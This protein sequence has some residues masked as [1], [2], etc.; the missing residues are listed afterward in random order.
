M[1]C[2]EA[3]PARVRSLAVVLGSLPSV[4]HLRSLHRQ[5]RFARLSRFAS[6]HSAHRRDRT[7]AV[8]GRPEVS[9][10]DGRSPSTAPSSPG[11]ASSSDLRRI[12]DPAQSHPDSSLIERETLVVHVGARW[13]RL[14]APKRASGRASQ[15]ARD[16][17][18]NERSDVRSARGWGGPRCGGRDIERGRPTRLSPGEV[19]T[20]AERA[21]R[22]RRGAHRAPGHRA[23]WG[24]RACLLSDHHS[25]C[26]NSVPGRF[27]PCPSTIYA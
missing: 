14:R 10:A 26:S 13:C 18:R 12:E 22:E 21:E 20:T 11:R 15:R 5:T 7:R 16:E 4:A 27:L 17:H 1:N 24:F 23:S 19:S 8:T 25:K 2:L 9:R 3:P 6:R